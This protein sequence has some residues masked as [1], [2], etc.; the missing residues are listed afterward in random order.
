MKKFLVVDDSRLARKKIKTFLETMEYQLIDEAED[1]CIALEIFKENNYEYDYIVMDLEM[2]NM[3]GNEASIK[4]LNLNP[5][6]KIILITSIIDK[7]EL[8]G[9]LKIGVKKILQKPISFKMFEQTINE[10]KAEK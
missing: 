10:L 3:K 9:A 7:K 4:M 5:N 6:A 8:I 2:P 1:G